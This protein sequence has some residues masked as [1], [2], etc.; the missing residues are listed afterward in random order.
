[1][2]PAQ[3][4][5]FLPL[6]TQP[7]SRTTLLVQQLILCILGRPGWFSSGLAQ[8]PLLWG[9]PGESM[10]TPLLNEVG[11]WVDREAWAGRM[12][13]QHMPSHRAH[14]GLPLALKLC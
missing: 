3:Q 10:A 9:G 14:E 12:G 1:M 5:V 8:G 11:P 4:F 13:M 2:F 6:Y 7:D